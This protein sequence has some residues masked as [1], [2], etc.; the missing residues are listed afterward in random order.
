MWTSNCLLITLL[1]FAAETAYG[2]RLTGELRL[3]VQDPSGAGMSASGTLEGLAAGIHRDFETDDRGMHT[4]SVLPFGVYRLEVRREGFAN[5]DLLIEVLSEVPASHIV[6]MSLG[7]L[8]T[9]VEIRDQQTLLDAGTS[10]TAQHLGGEF[11]DYR[12]T[13]APGRSLVDLVNLQPGWL[14]EANGVLH[15]RGSEYDVQYVIDGIPLYDNRS[16]AFAQALGV[17]EFET[18]TVR[19]GNYP[20]EFGRKLGGVIE[21]NTERDARIGTHGEISMQGGSFRQRSAFASVHHATG[22]NSFSMSGEGMK[23]DRY[24]DPPVVENYTNRGS[25]GGLS[26]RFDHTWSVSDSSRF[27]FHQRRTGFLVPNELLQQTAGQRQD[28]S[29]EETLGQASHSHLFSSQVL[30]QGRAM[31]RS[32]SARLWSNL[33][34]TP[35]HPEQDRGFREAYVGGSV[36]ISRGS[37]EWKFGGDGLFTSVREN[38][39][40][41]IVTRRLNNV[42]IFDGDVPLTFRFNEKGKRRE[43]SFFVQDLWRRGDLTLSSGLRFDRYKLRVNETGWSPRLAATYNVRPAGLVLRASF[44]RIFQQPAIENILLATTDLVADLGGEGAFLPLR[45]GRGNFVEAGFSKLVFN[46]F[47]LD[48]TWYHRRLN[49]FADDSLLLNTG[50]SFPI[51]FAEGRVHGYEA[52]FEVPR[53]GRFTSFVSYSNMAATGFLPVAGGLFLGDDADEIVTGDGSFPMTQ[54]QRNTFRSRVRVQVHPRVW[55]AFGAAYNSG[56]PFE[57]EGPA[58]LN[59]VRQQYGPA[60]VSKVNFARGRVQP[61]LSSDASMGINLMESDR[62]KVRIQADVFNLAGRLNVINFSGI[63][64]GTALEAGRNFAIRLNAGF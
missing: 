44:D 54:D 32:T 58:D 4:F 61:S 35:I 30:F 15:P 12:K 3:A 42:R 9:S 6:K 45:S 38:F 13:S 46:R 23:T 26:G 27:Y 59:F 29:A 28:R 36:S 20:A 1:F 52:K 7:T 10:G 16:P 50:V 41:T 56:L 47:R 48:G 21:I 25:G 49:H 31:F 37:H 22:R 57:I 2:Q 5:E 33:A 34:S 64:S 60:I 17:D 62:A 24:L 19:T 51:T 43:Q 53:W 55:F 14:L 40:Y 39:G 11:L 63:L 8:Q 18:V